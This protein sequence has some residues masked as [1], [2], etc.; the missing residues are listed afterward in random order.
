MKRKGDAVDDGSVKRQR[1][2][3][4][5]PT[6][7]G[8]GIPV[9]SAGRTWEGSE[10]RTE[11]EKPEYPESLTSHDTEMWDV[12]ETQSSLSSEVTEGAD[13]ELLPQTPSSL[14]PGQWGPEY[15]VVSQDPSTPESATTGGT[16]MWNAEKR[17][18]SAFSETTESDDEIPQM[19]FPT[20]IIRPNPSS[21]ADESSSYPTPR[22][23]PTPQSTPLRQETMS[24][25]GSA[26]RS[27]GAGRPSFFLPRHRYHTPPEGLQPS[28]FSVRRREEE[29]S[30][31]G[32]RGALAASSPM[33]ER[34]RLG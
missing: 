4:I 22:T 3:S 27:E 29:E 33:A 24:R 2:A 1:T 9:V 6:I 5:L 32:E 19:P 23:S 30:R 11:C 14:E 34:F 20:V 13:D 7:F 16:D 12:D 18:T 21:L 31:R 8:K 28:E 10:E 15:R 25:G 17:I 26:V